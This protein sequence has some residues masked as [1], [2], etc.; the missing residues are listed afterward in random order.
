MKFNPV[1][2]V[3][4]KWLL[5]AVLVLG[6]F[7]FSG[8]T[9]QIPNRLDKPGI[10]LT[11]GFADKVSRSISYNAALKAANQWGLS[12]LTSQLLSLQALS[13]LHS[14]EADIGVKQTSRLFISNN[15]VKYPFFVRTYSPGDDSLSFIG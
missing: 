11:G 8:L 15:Q 12:N 6:F 3:V 4:S 10:T 14:R 9:I 13:F 5:T 1:K 2:S 7:T